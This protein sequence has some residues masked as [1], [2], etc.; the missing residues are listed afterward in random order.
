MMACARSGILLRKYFIRDMERSFRFL[1]TLLSLCRK[2]YF[3][4][5]NYG[6]IRL[7]EITTRL[8]IF[9]THPIPGLG[10]RT[11]KS[12]WRYLIEPKPRSSIGPISN[13]WFSTYPRFEKT[14][15]NDTQHLVSINLADCYIICL[16]LHCSKQL[17][18]TRR[19]IHWGRSVCC[20]R[21][22]ITFGSVFSR[23]CGQGRRRNYTARS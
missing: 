1:R 21:K 19:K 4:M 16:I 6:K 12:P 17:E 9:F 20:M 11:F 14:M 8:L 13:I 10:G 18:G 3:W 23:Y 2:I 22:H 5:A 7:P 15:R